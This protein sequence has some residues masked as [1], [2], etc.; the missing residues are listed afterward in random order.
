MKRSFLFFLMTVVLLMAGCRADEDSPVG[1]TQDIRWDAQY[2]RTDGGESNSQYPKVQIIASFRDLKDYYNIYHEWYDLEPR[3][4]VYAD[5]TIGFLDAC[6]RYD[7]AFFEDH[8]LVFVLLEEPSGSVRHQV[9]G[10]EQTGDRKLSISVDR[11]IPEEGTD[12]MA[13][14]HIILELDR[15]AL[16]E[17]PEDVQVYLDGILAYDGCV[18]QPPQPQAR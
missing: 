16:V 12:D 4:Q 13:Q 14:W 18:V 5:T 9:L 1:Q 6:D 10:A 7:E 2:I 3:E 17:T 8:F 11:L 15:E